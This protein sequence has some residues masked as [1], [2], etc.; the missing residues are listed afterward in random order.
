MNSSIAMVLVLL[1]PSLGRFDF[2]G[3]LPK[4]NHSYY[5]GCRTIQDSAVPSSDLSGE[6][7]DFG[8]DY[9]MVSKDLADGSIDFLPFDSSDYSFREFAFD[10]SDVERDEQ[11]ANFVSDGGEGRWLSS[12]INSVLS[13]AYGNK[14]EE[15]DVGGLESAV[16]RLVTTYRVFDYDDGHL[17]EL[18]FASTGFL[19]GPDLLVCAAHSLF[20]DPTVKNTGF[21]DGM[22][23]PRFPDAAF[24]YPNLSE[25]KVSDG[26]E[27]ERIYIEKEYYVSNERDWGCAK[28][29]DTI[30]EETGYFGVI[31]EFK[32]PKQNVKML[33]FAGKG[34]GTLSVSTGKILHYDDIGGYYSNINSSLGQSGSPIITKLNGQDYVIGINDYGEGS[35]SGGII[36]D[37]FIFAF[38]DSFLGA[39][40]VE[41]IPISDDGFSSS[42]EPFGECVGMVDMTTPSG[43]EYQAM[44]YV[45]DPEV[46]GGVSKGKNTN[47]VYTE[48]SFRRPLNRVTIN[49]GETSDFAASSLKAKAK[50]ETWND[51]TKWTLRVPSSSEEKKSETN[52]E[53]QT[54]IAFDD[55][56]YRFR[57]SSSFPLPESVDVYLQTGSYFPL[58]GSELPYEPE[59]WNN[60]P[61][62]ENTNC[63]SYAINNQ[64]YPGTNNLFFMR[65]G[66]YHG[67]IMSSLEV[68]EIV[69][70][71]K[72][73]FAKYSN[74]YY[75]T[76]IFGSIGK[77][78]A[79][80]EGMYKVALLV[81]DSIFWHD[82]H[83]MR[84]D[85]DGYWSHKRGSETVRRYDF[86]DNNPQL[87]N[88]PETCYLGYYEFCGFY[89]VHPWNNM[90]EDV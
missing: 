64:V 5:I 68:D 28:L 13:S 67:V 37:D 19:A 50:L 22:V 24:F 51:E 56:V 18:N 33:G 79:P 21:D 72:R 59:K 55:L 54:T 12:D 46:A 35:F 90:H 62:V 49:F 23:N 25:N 31:R 7:T 86:S 20:L 65:P 34:N 85:A 76:Y 2:L 52:L 61:V 39:T 81:A 4:E 9:S 27:V 70:C 10:K 75:H 26:V 45:D 38:I 17:K 14:Q 60:D 43:I 87:I 82:F 30:G 40:N 74:T 6:K 44:Q 11:R 3:D 78:V 42:F 83:F 89:A 80:P 8:G 84:Q 69:Q 32:E 63:Y 73:D 41:T 88:D 71:C 29:S 77:Y 48:F 1:F 47:V 66:E 57:I 15:I 16:G 58:S 53:K 36:I